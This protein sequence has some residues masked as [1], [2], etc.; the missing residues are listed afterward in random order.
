MLLVKNDKRVRKIYRENP[1]LAV[2]RKG[3]QILML[4]LKTYKVKS[5]EKP[6]Y[7]LRLGSGCNLDKDL[8]WE[9]GKDQLVKYKDTG[10]YLQLYISI[11][12][13]ENVL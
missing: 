7:N 12:L 5:K 2:S 11:V 13:E 8:S 1:K 3:Y 4:Q 6:C 10:L 9:V